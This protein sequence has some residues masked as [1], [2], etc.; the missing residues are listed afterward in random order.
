MNVMKRTISFG[1]IDY[2]G[3]GRKTCPVEVEIALRDKPEGPEFVA[4]GTVWNHMKTD[5]YL[6]GQC[7]DTLADYIK[8]P[9]F[10]EIRELWQKH[11]LNSMHAGSP[12]QEEYLIEHGVKDYAEACKKLK[13]AG[14]LEDESY[15]YNG[16][17]YRYGTDWLRRDIPEK[18]LER[19]KELL[20][21]EN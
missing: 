7:L 21:E 8:N 12:K 11:H 15:I 10:E 6:F 1:K 20:N 19:I 18:D 3:I 16:K 9:E 13:E 14:L 5:C 17:P 2:L 4:A